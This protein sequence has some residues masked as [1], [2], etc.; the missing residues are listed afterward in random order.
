MCTLKLAVPFA[1]PIEVAGTQHVRGKV[2]A[3]LM[4]YVAPHANY[5][6]ELLLSSGMLCCPWN[7]QTTLEAVRVPWGLKWPV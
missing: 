7:L 3:K 2:A 4:V 5:S 6:L 1:A